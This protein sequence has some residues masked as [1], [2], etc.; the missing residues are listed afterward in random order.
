MKFEFDHRKSPLNER[1][2]GINFDDAQI[3]RDD[4]FIV[5]IPSKSVAGEE[6]RHLYIGLIGTKNWTAITTDREPGLTRIISVRRSRKEEIAL[7]LG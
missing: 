4:R 7:Y 1:K 3:L 5:K 6:T 2:H